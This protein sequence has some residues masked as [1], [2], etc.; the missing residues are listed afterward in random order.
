MTAVPSSVF[1]T[2]QFPHQE[3]IV[4]INQIDFY[5][6]DAPTNTTNSVHLLGHSKPHFEAIAVVLLK[7]SPIIKVFP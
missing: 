3:K 6:P 2:V 4:T 5:N 7:D 1:R